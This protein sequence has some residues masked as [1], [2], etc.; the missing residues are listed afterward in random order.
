MYTMIQVTKKDIA[1]AWGIL[2]RHS[3]G[4]A[5]P[6]RTFLVSEDAAQT[7]KKAGVKFKVISTGHIFNPHGALIGER[8]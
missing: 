2:V 4:H 3:P 7:L 1:K 6:D 5:F 8:I